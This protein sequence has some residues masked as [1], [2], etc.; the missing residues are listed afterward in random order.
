M[1]PYSYRRTIDDLNSCNVTI[2]HVACIAKNAA[3]EKL[4]HYLH[5]FAQTYPSPSTAVILSGD[6]NFGPVISNLTGFYS[7]NTVLI[8]N[9]QCSANLKVAAK[10]TILFDEFIQGIGLLLPFYKSTYFI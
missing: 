4:K 10:A 2:V 8:H 9:L 7:L 1:Y 3:D 5:R 6:M